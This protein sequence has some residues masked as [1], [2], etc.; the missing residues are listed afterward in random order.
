MNLVS[1]EGC[2]VVLDKSKLKFPDE[3]ENEDGSIDVT[4]AAWNGYR[5]T[6]FVNCP[7][8]GEQVLSRSA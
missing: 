4:R 8:C 7:V 2:G 1:C 5:H 3:I 6:P